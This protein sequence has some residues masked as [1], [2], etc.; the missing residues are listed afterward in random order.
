M[1]NPLGEMKLTQDD[2]WKILR[3][4]LQL[5]GTW[6][7]SFTEQRNDWQGAL[8]AMQRGILKLKPLITHRF[9]LKDYQEAFELMR[10]KKELYIK[11][12]FVLDGRAA[13]GD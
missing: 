7:S 6:N 4:E 2:Y 1:G 11:V 3:R 10:D 9:D 13:D 5:V 8:L 12:M